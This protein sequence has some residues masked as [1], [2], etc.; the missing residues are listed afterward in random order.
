M[1]ENDKDYEWDR[2]GISPNGII[3]NADEAHLIGLVSDKER[4]AAIDRYK[5]P[6]K[7]LTIK[8]S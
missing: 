7:R 6:P 1:V 2:K 3:Y 4:D 5:N 8:A